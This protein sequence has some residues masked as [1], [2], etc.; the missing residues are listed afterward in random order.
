MQLACGVGP[1][2]LIA[3]GAFATRRL[4][5]Y[6][7]VWMALR[8]ASFQRFTAM[9]K[10]GSG[11]LDKDELRNL[12]TWVMGKSVVTWVMGKSVYISL[13][14]NTRLLVSQSFVGHNSHL[15]RRDKLR[16]RPC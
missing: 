15:D 1:N 4:A 12:V 3:D 14:A 5:M 6:S 9:D 10:D 8:N 7:K 11:G 16:S 2:E 13:A